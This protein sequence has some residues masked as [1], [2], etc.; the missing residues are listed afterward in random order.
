[1]VLNG[2][3]YRGNC[4]IVCSVVVVGGGGGWASLGGCM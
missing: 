1:M 3:V 2:Q 4:E